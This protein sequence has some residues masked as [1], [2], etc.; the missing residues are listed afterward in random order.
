MEII[1]QSGYITGTESTHT[2]IING[3]VLKPDESQKLLNHSPDGFNW[4]YSGSGPAQ[5]ALAL[6]L[7]FTANPGYAIWNHQQF[8]EDIILQLHSDFSL[9]VSDV[10]QWIKEHPGRP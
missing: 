6:L 5:L 9:P 1:Y 7:H 3:E 4:G 8:K 10:A 2:I